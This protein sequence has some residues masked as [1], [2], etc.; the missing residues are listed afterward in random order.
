LDEFGPSGL[1]H[2]RA[3]HSLGEFGPRAWSLVENACFAQV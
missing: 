2:G 1:V 3:W